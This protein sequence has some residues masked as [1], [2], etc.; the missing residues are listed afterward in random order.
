MRMKILYVHFVTIVVITHV[1]KRHIADRTLNNKLTKAIR[2]GELVDVKWIDVK[3]GDILKV[4]KDEAIP[5]DLV[6]L[7]TSEP[8]GL[9][10]IETSQLDGET[11]LKIRKAHKNTIDLTQFEQLQKF[12]ASINC[13]APNN[14]LYNF[15]GNIHI[16]G[17]ANSAPIDV[18]Q[19]L[20]R[21]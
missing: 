4:M 10:Y 11:N 21:V 15:T 14:K 2:N 1:Q 3:V 9:C 5:A 7:S 19:I 6:C 12:N 8:N 17:E 13:E 18:E 16:E 20:L